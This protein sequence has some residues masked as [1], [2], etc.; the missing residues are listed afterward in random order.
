MLLDAVDE[1]QPR[2]PVVPHTHDALVT[3]QTAAQVST[4][5]IRDVAHAVRSGAP[6]QK[7]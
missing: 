5:A 6:L 3:D 4:L 2:C 7:S 1:R